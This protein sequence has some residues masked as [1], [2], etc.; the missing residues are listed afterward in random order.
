MRQGRQL[1]LVALEWNILE[2]RVS[3]SVASSLRS[4][5][6]MVGH[7]DHGDVVKIAVLCDG[8]YNYKRILPPLSCMYRS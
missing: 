2:I 6:V 7:L 8:V 1:C 3:S 5:T 4:V